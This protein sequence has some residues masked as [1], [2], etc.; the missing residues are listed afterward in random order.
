MWFGLQIC[1]DKLEILGHRSVKFPLTTL[2]QAGP[3][4]YLREPSPVAHTQRT[5]CK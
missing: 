3:G 5:I 2:E 4:A 1:D